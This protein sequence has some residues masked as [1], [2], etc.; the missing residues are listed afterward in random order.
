MLRQAVFDRLAGYED[1]ND[2]VRLRHDPTM[3]RIVGRQ[4]AHGCAVS[5]SQRGRFE[6]RWPAIATSSVITAE[7]LRLAPLAWAGSEYSGNFSIAAAS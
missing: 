7:R 6:T 4:A 3:R 5:P 2:A 1:V